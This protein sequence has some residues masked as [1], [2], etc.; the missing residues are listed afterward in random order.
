MD[1]W[2][3]IFQIQNFTVDPTEY[4]PTHDVHAPSDDPVVCSP[5]SG[6]SG[7][8]RVPVLINQTAAPDL[9]DFRTK[10]FVHWNDDFAAE[11]AEDLH[12]LAYFW[13]CAGLDI[14]RSILANQ[15]LQIFLRA[16]FGPGPYMVRH[17][18]WW[19]DMAGDQPLHLKRNTAQDGQCLG[20]HIL[21]RKTCVRYFAGSHVEDWPASTKLWFTNDEKGLQGFSKSEPISNGL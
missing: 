11:A 1:G 12:K 3:G 16:W 21:T 13:G 6:V 14:L 4:D 9:S 2:A 15:R 7:G 18:L 19:G 8:P 10:G 5:P 17:C 20:L